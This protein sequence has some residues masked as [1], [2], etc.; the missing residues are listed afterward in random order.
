MPSAPARSSLI[1]EATRWSAPPAPRKTQS[2]FGRSAPNQSY[3]ISSTRARCGGPS[4]T[5]A[6]CD[7]QPGNRAGGRDLLQNLNS[8][9]RADQPVRS[10]G[11]RRALAAAQEAGVGRIVAQ[12]YASARYAREGGWVK[13]EDDPL[14]LTP[15]MQRDRAAMTPPRR[16]R[17]SPGG[18]ALRYGGYGAEDDG[19]VWPVH[20][21]QFLSSAPGTAFPRS[22]TSTTP[23]RRRARARARGPAVYN[24][25]D[26]EPAPLREWLPVLADAR[27]Q[28]AP[29]FPAGSP[30]WSRAG[31]VSAMLATEAPRRLEREGEA[32]AR[33]S[34]VISSRRQGFP[35]VYASTAGSAATSTPGARSG[36]SRCSRLVD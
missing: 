18:I 6:R 14:D 1:D 27:G 24:I 10:E 31:P 19:L 25:V 20:K 17:S 32:R 26:D 29:P 34:S 4:S 35:A 8:K 11:H 15:W 5:P 9:L 16:R 23:P 22:S 7:R 3:S 12:S 21:R 28:A 30:G 36:G 13:T 33:G 2:A